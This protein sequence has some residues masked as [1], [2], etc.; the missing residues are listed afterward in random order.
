MPCLVLVLAC[1]P[2]QAPAPEALLIGEIPVVESV[3]RFLRERAGD[4]AR[5]A[6][7]TLDHQAHEAFEGPP[8]VS[9]GWVQLP[10]DSPAIFEVWISV[11][12]APMDAASLVS[13]VVQTP[14]G[15]THS[16]DGSIPAGDGRWHPHRADL[17]PFVGQPV[18]LTTVVRAREGREREPSVFWGGPMVFATENAARPT[19]VIL[20][21]CD[22]LRADHLSCYGYGRETSPRIDAL[23][24]DGVLFE[25]AI[26]EEAWTLPCHMTML[27]G[28]HPNRHRTSRNANLS[29]T[30]PTIADALTGE[31]YRAAGYTGLAVWLYDW[32]GFG[33]GF[34]LYEVPASV[35]DVFAVHASAD[36]WLDH[37]GHGDFFLFLHNY[38]IHARPAMPGVETPYGPA[39]DRFLHFSLETA[40]DAPSM[41][42]EANGQR[43]VANDFL[44][45]MHDG[46]VE[47]SPELHA[48]LVALYDDAIRSVDAAIGDL[49]DRLKDAGLYDDALIIVTSDHGEEL[50]ERGYYRHRTVYEEC[51]RVP[52]VVKFPRGQ[53]AGERYAHLVQM[54]DLFPTIAEVTGAAA[55]DD[56]DGTSLVAFLEGRNEP[57]ELA[58]AQRAQYRA[59][60]S[61]AHKFIGFIDETE[62]E[63]YDLASDPGERHDLFAQAPMEMLPLREAHDHFYG[64]TQQGWHFAIRGIERPWHG[65]ATLTSPVQL[66]SNRE[67]SSPTTRL[68]QSHADGIHTLEIEWEGEIRDDLIVRTEPPGQPIMVRVEGS[69]PFQ[70]RWGQEGPAEVAL[71]ERT[72]NPALVAPTPPERPDAAFTDGPSLT[73]WFVKPVETGEAARALTPEEL[74]L[75]ESLGYVN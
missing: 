55:P 14:D 12:D 22:T 10:E 5:P 53:F 66:V 3:H 51:A 2:K 19:P 62:P 34:D 38:D 36:A 71:F 26:V 18:Q 59:V 67:T 23:A 61:D 74:E 60:R 25:Q 17:S 68:R 42:Y 58:Y 52:L 39:D 69:E 15:D 47:N 8:E 30:I 49:V 16:F 20:I 1:S 35:R 46:L 45:A 29:E 9:W 75:M 13:I 57:R 21:S 6:R 72:L 50:G 41:V 27:T 32:R 31:G 44:E 28:L 48:H 54:A 40:A 65:K 73:V 4:G 37:H 7:V 24:Q 70:L 43:L 33:N 11:P 64:A 56:L 63:F